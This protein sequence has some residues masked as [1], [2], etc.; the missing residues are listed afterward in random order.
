MILAL[1]LPPT[2][3]HYWGRSGNRTFLSKKALDFRQVVQD[4]AVDNKLQSFGD[5]RLEVHVCIYPA[6]KAR[7][8]LDNRL[9]PLNDALMEAGL[10]DDDSQIDYLSVKRGEVVK[11]GKCIV[12]IEK[13]V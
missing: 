7:I 3:N 12:Y 5:A 9:K 11:A 2:I 1:P 13:L 6:T 4:Y 10:F 8:D